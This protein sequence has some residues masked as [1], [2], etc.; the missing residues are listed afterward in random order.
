MGQKKGKVKVNIFLH[1]FSTEQVAET[2]LSDQQKNLLI[3]Q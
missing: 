3:S 1:I 2:T